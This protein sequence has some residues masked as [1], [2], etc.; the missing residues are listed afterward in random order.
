MKTTHLNSL[1]KR[2]RNALVS[3]KLD[4]NQL[5]QNWWVQKQEKMNLKNKNYEII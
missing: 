2:N 3:R 4:I 5:L 1:N